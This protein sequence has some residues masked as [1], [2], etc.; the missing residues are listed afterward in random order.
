MASLTEPQ[1]AQLYMWLT[2]W[3]RLVEQAYLHYRMGNIP[4]T[5]WSGQVI[6]LKSALSTQSM[7]AFWKVRKS[8][9][10]EEFQAFVDQLDISNAETI[11]QMFSGFRNERPAA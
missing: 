10:S 9:Y 3:F 2:A 8:I 11:D 1:S 7:A 6:H 4:E 5:T